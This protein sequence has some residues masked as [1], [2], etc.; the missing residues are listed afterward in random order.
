[1]PFASFLLSEMGAE[2]VKIERPPHGDVIRGWDDAIG[3]L[4]SGFV[5]FNAGKRDI[6]VDASTD[7]GREVVRRLA[8]G[9]DVFLENFAPGVAEGLGLGRNALQGANH[10]LIYCSLSG[11]G[12]DGPY[13]DVKAYDLLV[14]GESGILLN[15]GT[16]DAP[17]K[18]GM[19]ITDQ[20]AGAHVVS[21]VIAALYERERTGLG[22]YIDVALLDT[23]F[24]WL[25]YYPQRAW[26]GMPELSRTGMRHQFICPYGPYLAADSEWVNLAVASQSHWVMFCEVLERPAWLR[27]PRFATM[28]TRSSNRQ[29]LDEEV[30]T[31][32]AEHPSEHW[33]DRLSEAGLPYGRVRTMREVVDHPQIA[34]RQLVS[35]EG[36]PVGDVK[37]VKMRDSQRSSRTVPGM[38]EH[39]SEV[40]KELGYTAAEIADLQQR[41]IV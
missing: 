21:R 39:T 15:N 37:V 5:A 41:G 2:V 13:R 30:E 3:G 29:L 17:A 35:E 14:Q 34:A 28:Q 16:D 25:G 26:Q 12:Q 6:A 4:S 19:P 11:Y 8:A 33:F 23:A 7:E 27:D 31:A 36:S 18:V 38:G 22:S 1:M 24:L 10:R 20:M 9:A 32:I 40:L